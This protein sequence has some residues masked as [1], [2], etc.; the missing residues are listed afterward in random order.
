MRAKLD[1]LAFLGLHNLENIPPDYNAVG[2]GLKRAVGAGLK[3]AVGAGV[4]R[5]VGAGLKRAVGAGLKRAVEAGVKR[6]VVAGGK[7]AVGAGGKRAVVHFPEIQNQP[8]FHAGKRISLF[9]PFK[10][11]QR[12]WLAVF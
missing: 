11:R 1:D 7:R 9:V 12:Q 5:A 4:K 6:A 3:R 10:L 2:A 8:I